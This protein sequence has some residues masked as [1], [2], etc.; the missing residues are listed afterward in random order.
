VLNNFF[1]MKNQAN[2]VLYYILKLNKVIKVTDLT[3]GLL[4]RYKF[5]KHIKN[6]NKKCTII[7]IIT[8]HF[9]KTKNFIN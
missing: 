5:K 3:T 2:A 9:L 1:D 4:E 6:Y 7:K 8:V